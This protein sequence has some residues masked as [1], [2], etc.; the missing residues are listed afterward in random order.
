[1]AATD[2]TRPRTSRGAACPADGSSPETNPPRPAAGAAH[3]TPAA[4][5]SQEADR[6]EAGDGGAAVQPPELQEI[7]DDLADATGVL[8][9]IRR[10]LSARPQA[11]A[12][13]K[14]ALLQD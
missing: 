13:D 4:G 10:S 5:S 2:H 6:P 12:V 14:D 3:G 8:R 11:D 9:V 7:L 1:M